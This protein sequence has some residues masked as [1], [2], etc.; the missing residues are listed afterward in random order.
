MIETTAT[1]ESLES[2]SPSIN[3]RK[4]RTLRW[5]AD[6]LV[7]VD[8]RDPQ[9]VAFEKAVVSYFLD[10][11]GM[12]AMPKSLAAIYGICFATPQPLSA[13]EIRERLDISA[14]SISTGLRFLR[15][16]GALVEVSAS[17]DRSERFEPDIELR[18]LILHYLE[19]RVERQLAVGKKQIGAIKTSIPRRDAAAAR[20]LAARVES[21]QGWHT[22]SRAL[23]PLVKGALQLASI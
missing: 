22:K 20:K 8:G 23:L 11:A 14:G 12:L 9:L 19:H 2:T 16:I 5:S 13:N 4:G 17:A 1:A 7:L 3:G 18:K 6:S 15:G 10:A 21:L